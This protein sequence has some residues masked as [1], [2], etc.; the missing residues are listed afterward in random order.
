[1]D[2]HKVYVGTGV[3]VR[4]IELIVKTVFSVTGP[5][6]KV[7][8]LVKDALRQAGSEDEDHLLVMVDTHEVSGKLEGVK[9]WGWS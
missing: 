3:G 5:S 4:G 8:D 1:M 6:E 2:T 7:E 9:V